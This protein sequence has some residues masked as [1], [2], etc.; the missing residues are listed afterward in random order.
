MAR[1]YADMEAVRAASCK[2]EA[3]L[4][5]I[6]REG[7]EAANYTSYAPFASITLSIKSTFSPAD[8]RLDLE[9]AFRAQSGRAA[10]SVGR[11]PPSWPKT[12]PDDCCALGG[13]EQKDAG[14][15]FCPDD[16]GAPG[17]AGFKWFAHRDTQ[18]QRRPQSNARK[19]LDARSAVR[20]AV[21]NGGPQKFVVPGHVT[22]RVL[23]NDQE[24]WQLDLLDAA[25]DC[26]TVGWLRNEALEHL[27]RRRRKQLVARTHDGTKVGVGNSYGDIIEE[28]GVYDGPEG[29]IEWEPVGLSSSAWLP[30][31]YANTFCGILAG[32]MVADLYERKPR[33]KSETPGVVVIPAAVAAVPE[34]VVHRDD[35]PITQVES[36]FLRA[37]QP[38]ELNSAEHVAYRSNPGR[39]SRSA[40]RRRWMQSRRSRRRVWPPT[41]FDRLIDELLLAARRVIIG[42]LAGRCEGK[43]APNYTGDVVSAPVTPS[44]KGRA[45]ATREAA[46]IVDGVAIV[47]RTEELP[48]CSNNQSHPPRHGRDTPAP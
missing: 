1:Q 19:D 24:R 16:D 3:E 25:C 36:I 29:R 45:R 22:E 38:V 34:P 2:W 6:E 43:E 31:L 20:E 11:V 27:G 44:I 42:T 37:H 5:R 48:K 35:A 15:D 33:I 18:R 40:S 39:Q 32:R 8:M 30:D 26:D 41:Y 4:D 47:H 7:K 14:I 23:V 17:N 9:A 28:T 13:I 10:F 21:R 12:T 46:V